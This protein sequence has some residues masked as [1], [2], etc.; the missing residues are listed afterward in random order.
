[1]L[2]QNVMLMFITVGPILNLVTIM[3]WKETMSHRYLKPS[4]VMPLM[5]G[6]KRMY[7]YFSVNSETYAN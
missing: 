7:K 4:K 3:L 1:M 6:H 2:N 5:E